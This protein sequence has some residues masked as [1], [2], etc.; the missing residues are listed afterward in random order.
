MDLVIMAAGIGS[1]FGGLKQLQPIDDNN[2]FIID[3]SIY[4]A[5]RVGFDHVVFIIK[6]EFYDEF[7]ETIG[8]RIAKYIDVDYVFQGN[9]VAVGDYKIPEDRIRPL[10]TGHAILCAKPY[11]KSDFAVINADDFY[12]F[13][14]YKV[15]SEFLKTNKDQDKYA[16]V[17]YEAINTTGKS[18]TVKRGVCSYED[19]IL[20]GIVESVIEKK[21]DKLF[22]TPITH[23]NAIGEYIEDDKLVSMNLFAFTKK[24][25]NY[26]QDYFNE[27]LEANKND[28]ST[29]EFFLPT[30][31]SNLI[32]VGKSKVSILSTSAKWYGITYKEDLEEFKLA[33]QN[34]INEG[35]YPEH[36]Y[37]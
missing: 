4:D 37:E 30:A 27:F 3:Y 5:I 12:G 2:N 25:L 1:R 19:G 32:K 14:A 24:F 16:L 9:D 11:I 7:K 34:M 33:I 6:K 13:D 22:A 31:V 28:L 23:E 20:T 8:N 18:G 36:L 35:K 17:G 15:A 10:G 29:C 26:L 21:D